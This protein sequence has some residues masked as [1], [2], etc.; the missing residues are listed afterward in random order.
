MESNVWVLSKSTYD[1]TQKRI[2]YVF[3]NI[4]I[5]LLERRSR[6]KTELIKKTVLL[7]L[8][9]SYQVLLSVTEKKIDI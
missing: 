1:G 3:L 6:M 9:V 2:M 5:Y 7:P 8:R 4:G